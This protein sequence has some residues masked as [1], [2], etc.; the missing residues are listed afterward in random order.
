METT[1]SAQHQ[2][3][4]LSEAFLDRVRRS[5]K[6]A[7]AAAKT[8]RH[9]SIWD[10]IDRH[11]ASVHAALFAD[12]NDELRN[13]FADPVAS[14]LFYGIDYF[15]AGTG[16]TE[17]ID[18]RSRAPNRADRPSP[19]RATTA[20]ADSTPGNNF[21][22]WLSDHF[23][24]VARTELCLLAR[25]LSHYEGD[26]A[27]FDHESVLRGADRLLNQTIQFPTFFQGALG[28]RTTRGVASFAAIQAVYQA[29]RT[30]SLTATCERKSVIEIGPGMGRA[31]Y[32]AYCAG[33]K[34]YTTVDLPMGIVAQACFLGAALGPD[35]IWMLGDDERL[36]EG[37]IKLLVAGNQPN[38]IYGL[39]VNVD[40]MTE[41]P[42]QAALHYM[43]W[44]YKH[45][46]LFLSINHDGNLFTVAEISTKW[47]KPAERRRYP[48]ADRYIEE[49]YIPRD[50]PRATSWHR[51]AWHATKTFT[52]R[53]YY[54]ALGRIRANLSKLRARSN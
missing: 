40:S 21:D 18:A 33:L 1:L 20:V 28:L 22:R 41:M 47:F 26:L 19:D 48:M 17:V 2:S 12:G 32:Y 38:Q 8:T 39:A 7:L 6:I 15:W 13:I 52:R 24:G 46:R 50:V 11:R 23:S 29:W 36:A 53:N 31:A 44:I 34:N 43:N 42:L 51:I 25:T 14:D 4:Y 16:I 5:Y 9:G 49:I 10:N 37:R 3:G 35:K 54:R 45:S 27:S 30:V